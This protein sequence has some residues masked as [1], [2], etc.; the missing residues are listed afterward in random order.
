MHINWGD[1]VAVYAAVVSTGSLGW[2][3]YRWRLDRTGTLEVNVASSGLDRGDSFSVRGTIYNRNDYPVKL[4]GLDLS[5]WTRDGAVRHGGPTE[6][7]HLT[8]EEPDCR[9]KSPPATA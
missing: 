1:V 6:T 7:S 3:V 2:Q 4:S 5:F 8:A 9:V